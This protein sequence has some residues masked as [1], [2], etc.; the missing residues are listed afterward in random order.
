LHYQFDEIPLL[1]GHD[2]YLESTKKK[3][4]FGFHSDGFGSEIFFQTGDDLSLYIP[5]HDLK[6]STGGRLFVERQA[7][8]SVWHKDRNNWIRKFANY[9][10]KRGATDHNGLVS[11]QA[12]LDSPH[13]QAIAS[14]FARV[15]HKRMSL[16]APDKKKMNSI[17]AKRGEVIIFGNKS[18]H[19]VE[20]WKLN[21]RRKIYVVRLFPLYDMKMAPPT[22]FLNDAPCNRFVVDGRRGTFKA[23]DCDT[24][25]LEFAPIPL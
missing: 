6:E 9:C 12:I 7:N 23:I 3:R 10:R 2:I 20:P 25:V 15:L 4:T 19:A 1:V 11:R 14:K 8:R 18:F 17:D 16:P 5:L 22:T 21:L 24:D 13:R